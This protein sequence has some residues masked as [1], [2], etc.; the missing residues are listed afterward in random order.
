MPMMSPPSRTHALSL[1]LALGCAPAFGQSTGP[2]TVPFSEAHTIA[3]TAVAVPLEYSLSLS[4]AGT[5][6]LALTDYG[7]AHG[8]P[9]ASI[10]LAVTLGTALVP[11]TAGGSSGQSLLTG[12]GTGSFT[13]QA[14]GTYVIHVT[15]V[16]G[17]GAGSGLVGVSVSDAQGDPVESF[18]GTLVPPPGAPPASTAQI[19]ASTPILVDSDY[20]IT[21]TDFSFPQSL[22]SLTL[23]LS[24]PEALPAPITLSETDPTIKQRLSGGSGIIDA[25]G[26]AA[27]VNGGLY[28]VILAPSNTAPVYSQA[29][30]VGSVILLASPT[31]TA[32]S[33][34]VTLADLDYPAALATAGVVVVQNGAALAQLAAAGAQ[35]FTAAAGPA[36]VYAVA[37][38]AASG[39]ATL[40]GTGSYAVSLTSSGGGVALDVA[41]P[42][43]SSGSGVSVYYYDTQAAASQ[44]YNL[45]LSDFAYPAAFSQIVAA[46]A[47]GIGPAGAPALLGTPVPGAGAEALTAASGEVSLLVFARP[48]GAG[49]GLFGLQWNGSQ[50]AFDTTQ[51]TGSL[52]A[53]RT[54]GVT[55]SGRYQVSLADLGFPASFSSLDVVVTSG[56]SVVAAAAHT[57]NLTFTAMPG[58]Y[59]VSI[60]GQPGTATSDAG[61]YALNVTTAQAASSSSG[62]GG[63]AID[64]GLLAVL[65]SAAALRLGRARGGDAG[66]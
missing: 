13:A 47:Q 64:G 59:D 16:A 15:G 11:L 62:G 30:P 21:L 39:S 5:Y 3:G 28:S 17:T 7:A 32:Q 23:T 48:A 54:I 10:A 49:T 24:D 65:L 51:G 37:I 19:Y 63:G 31:L 9:V 57:G 20:N 22:A 40:P 33:Y 2:L 1:L 34:T 14:A 4:S 29:V 36:Q 8:S 12:A 55:D 60:I 38:P 6:T 53:S 45:V 58:N 43:A 18:S 46:A 52:F 44:S 42:A 61:T 25:S 50:P 27:G 26:Q 56:T 35:T 66:R 41:R